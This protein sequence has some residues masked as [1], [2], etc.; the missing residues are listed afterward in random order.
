ML[1][2]RLSEFARVRCIPPARHERINI[3]ELRAR[4]REMTDR[5][6]REF[7]EAARSKTRDRLPHQPSITQLEEATAE[8]RRRHPPRNRYLSPK[9]LPDFVS[10]K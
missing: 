2:A 1:I 9:S 8:W 5:E 4:L 10:P 6:L 3:E 7:G